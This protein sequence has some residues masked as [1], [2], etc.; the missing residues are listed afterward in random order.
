LHPFSEFGTSD[1]LV[2]TKLQ[3]EQIFDAHLIAPFGYLVD[4]FCKPSEKNLSEVRKA[5]CMYI[6]YEIPIS[7]RRSFY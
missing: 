4:D 1:L 5:I 6:R 2:D 3:L 7:V